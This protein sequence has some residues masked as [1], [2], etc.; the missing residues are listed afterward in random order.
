MGFA[1]GGAVDADSRALLARAAEERGDHVLV[2]EEVH[3]VI[4]VE[5][6]G[7]WRR[8]A[9]SAPPSAQPLPSRNPRRNCTA[10]YLPM[11]GLLDPVTPFWHVPKPNLLP[12]A[13]HG[14]RD[15]P[16][17]DRAFYVRMVAM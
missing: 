8:G 15:A 3:P 16:G 10:G 1:Q 12:L 6:G 7:D 4:V 17:I 5:A 13:C 11:P 14:V 2:V 9:G